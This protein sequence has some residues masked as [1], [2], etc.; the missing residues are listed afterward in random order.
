MSHQFNTGFAEPLFSAI[1]RLLWCARLPNCP[2]PANWRKGRLTEGCS[3]RRK[4]D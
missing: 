3:F 1:P 4:G 2:L